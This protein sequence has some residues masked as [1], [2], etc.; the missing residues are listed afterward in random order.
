MTGGEHGLSSGTP[1]GPGRSSRVGDAVMPPTDLPVAAVL[2]SF[3]HLGVLLE[4]DADVSR[5]LDLAADV[6]AELMQCAAL[7]VVL[8]DGRRPEHISFSPHDATFMPWVIRESDTGPW[9]DALDDGM[10]HVCTVGNLPA[11]SGGFARRARA[12]GAASCVAFP[13]RVD[14]DMEPRGAPPRAPGAL[15]A[16]RLEPTPWAERDLALGTALAAVMAAQLHQHDAVLDATRRAH[17]LQ[18]ALDGRVVLEQAKG[19]TAA[20]LDVTVG[21]AFELLRAWARR[22]RRSV[23]DVA[24]DVVERRLDARVLADTPS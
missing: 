6:A 20:T 24:A 3:A 23:H 19:M 5:Y 4:R 21:A 1:G 7:A 16:L 2:G 18:V 17:Q 22:H 12:I 8:V 15:V 9:L 11:H 10:P 14:D 13:L